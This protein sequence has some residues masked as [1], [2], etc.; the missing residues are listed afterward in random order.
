MQKRIYSPDAGI[1][2]PGTLLAGMFRDLAAARSLGFRLSI[3]NLSARYRQSFLGIL[4]A[5]VPP[6]ASS[7]IWIILNQQKIVTFGHTDVPYP[8]YVITGTLLWQFFSESLTGI[9]NSL[10][11]NTTMLSKLNFPREA[12]LVSATIE[13]GL[14]ALIKLILLVAVYLSFGLYFDVAV[15]Q[16]LPGLILLFLLGASIGL[17]LIPFSMLIRDIQNGIGLAL[18]FAMYLTPVIYPVKVH[19]GWLGF[20][21]YNPVTPLLQLCRDGLAG[22]WYQNWPEVMLIGGVIMIFLFIGL[23]AFRLSMPILIERMGS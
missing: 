23:I 5:L 13:I 14:N 22:H 15:I 19:H 1:R 7:L 12:L 11:S 6:L 20:L 18:Q 21:N 8:V 4:W 3:R 16:A 10:N 9:L 2:N 17:F